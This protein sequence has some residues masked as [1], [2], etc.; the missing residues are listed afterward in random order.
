MVGRHPAFA[1]RRRDEV[2]SQG[3]GRRGLSGGQPFPQIAADAADT[4]A[5]TGSTSVLDTIVTQN[6]APITAISAGMAAGRL[7]FPHPAHAEST[8]GRARRHPGVSG[9]GG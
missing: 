5:D 1:I 3:K 6:N 9:I 4:D 2:G 8:S 7:R